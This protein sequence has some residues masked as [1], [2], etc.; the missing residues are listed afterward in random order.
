ML[1]HVK[2]WYTRVAFR[3]QEFLLVI[4]G[5]SIWFLDIYKN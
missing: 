5:Q 1:M 3:L 2:Y 4:K